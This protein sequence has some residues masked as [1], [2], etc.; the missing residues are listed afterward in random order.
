MGERTCLISSVPF[1]KYYEKIKIK[2]YETK[3]SAGLEFIK[4]KRELSKLC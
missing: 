1:F 3:H 2:K 4:F